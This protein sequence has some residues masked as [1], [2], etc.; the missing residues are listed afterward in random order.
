MWKPQT[1]NNTEIKI[2]LN[3]A[4]EFFVSPC[5]SSSVAT[6]RNDV[7]LDKKLPISVLFIAVAYKHIWFS[8]SNSASSSSN[9]NFNF[10]YAVNEYS[11][12][13]F[14][15][16]VNVDSWLLH[17]YLSHSHFFP[18]LL[19]I[20]CPSPTLSFSLATLCCVRWIDHYSLRKRSEKKAPKNMKKK[21]MWINQQQWKCCG[22]ACLFNR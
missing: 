5:S 11:S 8:S 19:S 15:L 6:A 9:N 1:K 10:T 3:F 14:I 13:Y 18:H 4:F 12:Q 22:A 20:S 2:K 7:A 17:C 21:N 16:M